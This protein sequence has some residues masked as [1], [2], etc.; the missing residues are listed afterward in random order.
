MFL[1]IK[2][3]IYYYNIISIAKSR[4]LTTRKQAK[5]ALGYTELHHIIPK[6]L[7]GN[8][9][10]ENTVF[11]TAREHFVCH[12]LLV[13]M[14]TGDAKHKMAFAL[15]RML[16]SNIKHNRYIPS[17]KLYEFSRK[18]RSAAISATHKGIPES[19][20]SNLKRS[21]TQKGVPKGPMLEITK[22]KLSVALK[23]K[24]SP[25]KGGTTSLKGMSYEEIHGI[26]KS[27]Q[28][29]LVRS[30][31]LKG[32]QF[33]KETKE[34]WSVNRKGKGVGGNNPNA[35]PVVLNGVSYSSV[36]EAAISLGISVYKLKQLLA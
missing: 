30:S 3:T 23:G 2:Y 26:E 16:T 31:Q 4:N 34:L 9:T 25:N 27:T 22:Q 1:Q 19:A 17:S 11:L 13:K 6:C 7:G 24:S 21:I 28:L 20:E 33:S 14:L 32:R 35:K 18:H 5:E 10:N 8:D 12:M 36:K 15:N 29:K